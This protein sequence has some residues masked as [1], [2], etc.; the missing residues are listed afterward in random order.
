MAGGGDSTRAILFALGANFAIAVAKG[1]AAFFTGSSAMLAETVHS[2]ADCG[3]QGLLILGLKQAK[4]PPS[5]DYPLGYGKA[6]YFW[7]FLVAV[8][9]FTVGGMFSLYE[10][11]HKLQH[12]EPLKQWWWAAGVLVFGIVAEAVSMRACLQEVNKARGQRSLWQ[13]FRE[14]RQAELVVIFGEDLAA[15]L[16]LVLALGAVM[17]TVVTGNPIWDAIG[18]VSIG[19]LLIIVAVF[20]AIE[21]KAMLIGQSVDPLRQQQIREFLD[22]RPEIGRVISV[23]TLQLGNEVMVSVQAQMREEHSVSG[24][25][26]QINTVERAMKQAFPEVRWSFFEPDYKPAA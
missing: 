11:I 19:A 21:V 22:A 25:T 6:I 1:V 10:G 2:L 7:S 20:V 23:I 26:E 18:T 15:L 9:L 13:W 4:R 24:L 12:P 5:P 8:M 17:M 3:N 14:S 16:G